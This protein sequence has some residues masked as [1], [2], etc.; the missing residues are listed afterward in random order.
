MEKL[1][2][3]QAVAL[4]L[5]FSVLMCSLIQNN[6]NRGF[7]RR[8]YSFIKNFK[9]EIKYGKE[10]QGLHHVSDCSSACE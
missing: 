6:L 4:K 5:Q 8:M 1:P 7:G 10:V 3:T 9:K 2:A